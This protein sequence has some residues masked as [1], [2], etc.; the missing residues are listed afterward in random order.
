MSGIADTAVKIF[1]KYIAKEAT[2]PIGVTDELRQTVI[3][4]SGNFKT[5]RLTILCNVTFYL[6]MYVLL[7]F[8]GKICGED[9]SVDPNSFV[10]CQEFAVKLMQEKW[11]KLQNCFNAPKYY[12]N[13][14]ESSDQCIVL[15]MPSMSY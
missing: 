9:G 10:P 15:P 6:C 7:C 4:T 12:L 3:R 11:V 1:S 13:V 2:H 8:L 5:C 14:I